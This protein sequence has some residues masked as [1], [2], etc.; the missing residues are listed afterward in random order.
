MLNPL[1][2]ERLELQLSPEQMASIANIQVAAIGQAEEGFY[3]NP[4]PSYLLALGIRPG[5][6]REDEIIE[7]YKEYQTLKRQSNGANSHN[8]KLILNPI[9]SSRS[10]PLKDWRIQ[11]GLAT[12]GLCSAFCLHMPLVNRLEKHILTFT[13][14]P[15]KQLIVALTEAD[16]DLD[17]FVEACKIHKASLN[18]RIRIS[19]NLPPVG[20]VAV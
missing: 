7:A 20:A 16:Y 17:E 3:P 19:N 6:P 12:Y 4:L 13:E 5:T 8:P 18:N 1:K 10:N 15:P 11:S 2:K 9:F 14:L